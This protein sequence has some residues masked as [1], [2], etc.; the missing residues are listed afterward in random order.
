LHERTPRE[1]LSRILLVE[2]SKSKHD[3]L[4][5]TKLA[6]LN[7]LALAGLSRIG[8]AAL[9]RTQLLRLNRI[10]R[11]SKLLSVLG[12]NKPNGMQLARRRK[13]RNRTRHELLREVNKRASQ[14]HRKKA[15]RVA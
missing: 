11:V 4:S 14:R 13:K 5:R 7:S 15:G 1:R 12:S 10:E 9:N 8:P 3:V 6:K 2:H